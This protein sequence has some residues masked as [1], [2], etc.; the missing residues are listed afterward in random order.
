MTVDSSGQLS[1]SS[2]GIFP[3]SSLLSGVFS[4]RLELS[5]RRFVNIRYPD[6]GFAF[7]Q[8]IWQIMCIYITNF[9][10]RQVKIG[11]Y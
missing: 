5:D 9:L 2:L 3:L 8:D 10:F 11:L 7:G 6:G 4:F 1:L